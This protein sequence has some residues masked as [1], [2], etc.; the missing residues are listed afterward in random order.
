VLYPARVHP[1][2]Q[3]E[4]LDHFLD[5]VTAAAPAGVLGPG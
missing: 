4:I 2:Q 1:D 3:G 5:Q